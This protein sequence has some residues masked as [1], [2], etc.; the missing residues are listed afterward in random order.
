M[1]QFPQP[2]NSNEESDNDKEVVE[3]AE[4]IELALE[5]FATGEIFSFSDIEADNY[6]SLKAAEEGLPPGFVTPI[7]ELIK[8]FKREGMK[9]VLGKHPQSGNIFIMPAESSVTDDD[10]EANS[11]FPR[12]LQIT[13]DMDQRLK[14]LIQ[15]DKNKY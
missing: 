1:E 13:D 4:R 5:L 9:I 7:D 15:A 2:T 8:R 12:H 10:I 14:E 11:I 3:R 6:E